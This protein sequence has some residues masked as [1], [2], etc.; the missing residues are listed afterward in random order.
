MSI[1]GAMITAVTGLNAQ[2]Y[3]LENISDNIANSQTTGYKRVDTSFEDM[4]PDY[5]VRTQVGGSVIAFSQGTNTLTGTI[6]SSGVGTNFAINGQ[7]F[8]VVRDASNLAGGTPTF[9]A[10]DLYTRRGDFQLDKN[11]F[12]VNGAGKY[13][14]GYA[15]SATGQISTGTPDVVK[16]SFAP[17]D[18]QATSTLAYSANIPAY[19]LTQNSNTTVANSEL[20]G[21]GTIT[22]PPATITTGGTAPADSAT[23]A[24][25]S[26]AGQTVTMYDSLGN[27]VNVEFRWAKINSVS[28][29][30]TDTWALYYNSTPGTTAATSTWTNIG[31]AFT[32]NS[33]G[34][35]TSAATAS[36]AIAVGGRTVGTVAIDFTQLTQFAD[37][38]GQ[39]KANQ[40]VQ[41]GYTAGKLDS[42]AIGDD[43][44]IMATYTNGQTKAIGQVALAQFNAV[45]ALKRDSGGV[46]SETLESGQPILSYNGSSLISGSLEGSNTDIASEFSKMIV[47]QQ[48]YSANTRVITTSQQMLQDAINIIR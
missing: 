24:A 3:A 4:V 19:P 6:T 38:S 43:G 32:F 15:A 47:T 18:A 48:A 28:N 37:G 10:R 44:R 2:S 34:K 35:L 5:P 21:G 13:L 1:F 14:V 17:V 7:G 25:N 40:I 46:F 8:A 16:V 26:I 39:V 31:G 27:Q 30:A 23:F 29:G 22:T 12:L 33:T 36:P 45:N 42:V 11:G 9:S 20:W 41:N